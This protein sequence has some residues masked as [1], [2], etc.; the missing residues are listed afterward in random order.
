[1]G[2]VR[3]IVGE[4]VVGDVQVTGFWQFALV[5][6][7]LEGDWGHEVWFHA[8]SHDVG[9]HSRGQWWLVRA[10][11][12]FTDVRVIVVGDGELKGVCSVGRGGYRGGSEYC[13]W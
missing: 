3:Q 6:L 4:G 9:V 5:L 13:P 8:E 10:S 2:D 11:Y 12:A 1:M 7:V